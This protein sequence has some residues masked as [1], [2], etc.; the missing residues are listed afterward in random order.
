MIFALFPLAALAWWAKGQRTL[1]VERR[2]RDYWRTYA[3]R[4]LLERGP[5]VGYWL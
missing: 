1:D 4:E 5:D 2:D 3:T